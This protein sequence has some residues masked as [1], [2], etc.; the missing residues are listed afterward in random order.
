MA[1]L[2]RGSQRVV[3]LPACTNWFERVTASGIA[4]LY[5]NWIR[6]KMM[7]IAR[8]FARYFHQLVERKPPALGR[9]PPRKPFHVAVPYTPIFSFATAH[10]R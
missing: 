8:H 10:C 1:V 2:F 9:L 3:A 7:R 5:G 6:A 4:R